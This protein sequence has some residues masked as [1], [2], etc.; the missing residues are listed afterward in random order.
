MF[1]LT[2]DIIHCNKYIYIHTHIKSSCS[3][4][5]GTTRLPSFR[6]FQRTFSKIVAVIILESSIQFDTSCWK[7]ISRIKLYMLY[8]NKTYRRTILYR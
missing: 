4:R 3:F 2:L 7:I 1:Q 6:R 8:I 5:Q